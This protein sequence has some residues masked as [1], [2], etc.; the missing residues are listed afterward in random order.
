MRR[1]VRCL[2]AFALLAAFDAS[3]VNAQVHTYYTH[4]M[5]CQPGLNNFAQTAYGEPGIGNFS[6]SAEARVFCPVDRA[7]FRTNIWPSTMVSVGWANY[8]DQSNS[9]P[10]WGYMWLL[11]NSGATYWSV[12]KYT[13][14]PAQFGGCFDLTTEYV[15]TGRLRWS[16]PFGANRFFNEPTIGYSFSIPRVQSGNASWVQSYNTWTRPSSF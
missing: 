1:H 10:F 13:C 2:A 6:A 16:D 11:E 15:G 9:V 5:S 8:I 12:K 4:G 3:V 14:S 7:E